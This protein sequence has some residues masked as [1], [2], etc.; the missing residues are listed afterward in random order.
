MGEGRGRRGYAEE[1]NIME[2]MEQLRILKRLQIIN[3][4]DE[5]TT[6]LR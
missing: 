5:V 1:N 2:R 6:F 3:R 4:E